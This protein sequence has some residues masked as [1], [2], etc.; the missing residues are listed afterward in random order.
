M[1]VCVYNQIHFLFLCFVNLFSSS[2]L[3]WLLIRG[4]MKSVR[5]GVTVYVL[6]NG[7]SAWIVMIVTVV[8]AAEVASRFSSQC[9]IA[10]LVVRFLPVTCTATR[11][12]RLQID[13]PLLFEAFLSVVFLL[14]HL[15]C[16]FRL[17]FALFEGMMM[18]QPQSSCCCCW[19]STSSTTGRHPLSRP[20][21]EI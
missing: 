21:D 1:C 16:R 4:R 3:L 12:R 2:P 5:V 15:I 8:V 9:L 7:T 6:C 11:I 20:L 13:L 18:R 19:R 10:S 17:P 14:S